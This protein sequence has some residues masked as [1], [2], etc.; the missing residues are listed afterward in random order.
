MDKGHPAKSEEHAETPTVRYLP[1][2]PTLPNMA[3]LQHEGFPLKKHPARSL[4]G[5]PLVGFRAT[6]SRRI[7]VLYGMVVYDIRCKNPLLHR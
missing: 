3:V 5:K 1:T 6:T 7:T 2:L 4:A